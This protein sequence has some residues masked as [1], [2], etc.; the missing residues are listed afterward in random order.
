[1]KGKGTLVSCIFLLDGPKA[2][3]DVQVVMVGRAVQL[4]HP[5]DPQRLKAPWFGDSTL[6]P[7]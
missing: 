4:L 6:E 3:C 1:M 2:S 5:L 7:I